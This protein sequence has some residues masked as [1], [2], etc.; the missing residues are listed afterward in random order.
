MPRHRKYVSIFAVVATGLLAG[1]MLG[2]AMEQET[3]QILSPIA[4]SYVRI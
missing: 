3:A 2:V 4:G 1:M